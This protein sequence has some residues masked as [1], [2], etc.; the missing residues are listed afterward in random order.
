MELSAGDGDSLAGVVVHIIAVGELNFHI[1][2][3]SAEGENTQFQCLT[4]VA[5]ENGDVIFIIG[6]TLEVV[7]GRKQRL[8][9]LST[10]EENT[11][12]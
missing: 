12:A 6:T 1:G 4:V 7:I 5:L 9:Q 8:L 10:G 3:E 2:A 11:T